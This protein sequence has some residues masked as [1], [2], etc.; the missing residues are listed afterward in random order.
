MLSLLPNKQVA[1]IES[2]AQRFPQ[3]AIFFTQRR[4]NAHFQVIHREPE[5]FLLL[6]KRKTVFMYSFTIAIF[7]FI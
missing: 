3:S 7:V 6:F 5:H 4:L 2:Q 1:T